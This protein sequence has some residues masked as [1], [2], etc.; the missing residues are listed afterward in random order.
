MTWACI[1][2]WGFNLIPHLLIQIT[3]LGFSFYGANSFGSNAHA[4]DFRVVLLGGAWIGTPLYYLGVL[5]R[6]FKQMPRNFHIFRIVFGSFYC[7]M[8]IGLAA[9]S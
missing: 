1:R 4:V 9:L 7:L 6:L 5:P 2:I 3:F 8:I